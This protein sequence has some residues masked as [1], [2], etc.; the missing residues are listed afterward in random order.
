MKHLLICAA[1]LALTACQGNDEDCS[2]IFCQLGGGKPAEKRSTAVIVTDGD[3]VE[4]NGYAVRL[5]GGVLETGYDSELQDFTKD[6]TLSVP[7]YTM[8]TTANPKPAWLSC[9]VNDKAGL[10]GGGGFDRLAD[11]IGG[12]MTLKLARPLKENAKLTCFVVPQE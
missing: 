5:G 9:M 12:T 10:V 8:K 7:V 4:G 1:A 11:K 6:R 3:R 2:S